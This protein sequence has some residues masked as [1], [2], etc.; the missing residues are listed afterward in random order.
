MAALG[1]SVKLLMLARC[2][3][4][5]IVEGF[6]F[7]TVRRPGSGERAPADLCRLGCAGG[8]RFARDGRTSCLLP[9]GRG[10]SQA[11]AAQEVRPLGL[12]VARF[13]GLYPSG[14]RRDSVSRVGG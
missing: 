6:R 4:A 12:L 14:A 10:R 7:F 3:G 2:I 13:P 11:Q 9:A 8:A 1:E 5:K